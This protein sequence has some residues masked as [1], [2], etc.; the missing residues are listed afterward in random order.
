MTRIVRT[1]FYDIS[2][3][4][5][6]QRG[7]WRVLAEVVAVYVTEFAKLFLYHLSRKK[8]FDFF[9]EN[10]KFLVRIASYY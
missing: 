5:D 8:Q 3:N 4:I 2:R 1:H 10:K 9:P 6:K 7:W